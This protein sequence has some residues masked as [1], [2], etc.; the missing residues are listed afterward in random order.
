MEYQEEDEKIINISKNS[1]FNPQNEINQIGHSSKEL[2]SLDQ[3]ENPEL[4][5]SDQ[6]YDQC[7]LSI[8]SYSTLLL[9]KYVKIKEQI[10]QKSL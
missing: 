10:S 1:E 4:L 2:P 3:P 9:L 6:K 5:N 8:T 7:M